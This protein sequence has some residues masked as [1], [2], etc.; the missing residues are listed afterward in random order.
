MQ[1][2]KIGKKIYS[3]KDN[4]VIAEIYRGKEL[5]DS[6]VFNMLSIGFLDLFKNEKT[7]REQRF[8]KAHT[9]ADEY[10]EQIEKY[11]LHPKVLNDWFFI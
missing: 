8:L 10:L 1:T 6:K 3:A 11:E 2:I 7:L 5:V 4:S 9:W